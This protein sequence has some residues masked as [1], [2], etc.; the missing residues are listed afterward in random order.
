M[1]NFADVLIVEGKKKNSVLVVGLDPDI[2]FFP[3]FLLENVNSSSNES[4]TNAIYEF[5][6]IIIDAV[7]NQVV[8]VKPQLAYYE[9]YGS[10][11]IR[12]LEKTITYARSK[13]LIVIN[14]AKRGDIGSTSAAYARAFLGNGTIS[15]DMVTVNPF[16]GSDGYMPFI[17]AA[18][19]NNKGLFLLLKTSNPSSYEIQ[20][21]KLENGELL[22]FKMA[23]EIEK[24]ACETIG[25]NKYSFIGAVVGATYPEEAKKIRNMLPHSIF[26]VPGFGIQG[27]KAEDTSV[28][29]DENGNGAVISSSR[30]IIYSYMND[31]DDWRKTTETEMHRYIT[32]AATKAKEQINEIRFTKVT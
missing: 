2:K 19:E 31:K 12:A 26:L 8:A 13:E 14:D 32:E 30:G 23:K 20:D 7:A 18:K 10:Y 28:F 22:Y 6:K 17:E 5:N 27:G 4:I 16:L 15:G 3:D 21:L 24:L 11:G 9:V 29:F 25:I 1:G